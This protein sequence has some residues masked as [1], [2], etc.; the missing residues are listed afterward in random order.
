MGLRPRFFGINKSANSIATG[1]PSIEGLVQVNKTLTANVSRISDSNGIPVG[2]FV[3]QW[4]R[5]D[6]G[7]E[8]NISGANESTYTVVDADVGKSLKVVVSFVDDGGFSEGPLVS[9][10]TVVVSGSC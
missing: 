1:K 3:Y 7:E 8:T 2:S 4:V 10:V 5:V 9:D 6:G